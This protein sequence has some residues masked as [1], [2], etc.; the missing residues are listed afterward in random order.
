[1]NDFM[2]FSKRFFKMKK[3][4]LWKSTVKYI[5]YSSFTYKKDSNEILKKLL[6]NHDE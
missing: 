4:M 6:N 1:M 2:G 3:M 5:L